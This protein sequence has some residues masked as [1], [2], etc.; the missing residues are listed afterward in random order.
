MA[1]FVDLILDRYGDTLLEA[2]ESGKT[3]IYYNFNFYDV[4]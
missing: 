4:K 2:G 1:E 3:V